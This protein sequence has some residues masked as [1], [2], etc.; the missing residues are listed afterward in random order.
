LRKLAGKMPP[1]LSATLRSSERS[2]GHSG[3]LTFVTWKWNSTPPLGTFDGLLSATETYPLPQATDWTALATGIGGVVGAE[4]GGVGIEGIEVG[5]CT[6]RDFAALTVQPV[7]A[8]AATDTTRIRFQVAIIVYKDG[9]L[10]S[11]ALAFGPEGGNPSV[12]RG[13]VHADQLENLRP[14]QR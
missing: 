5:G 10:A 14:I 8:R 7:S 9:R 6:P 13:M 11:P 3:A 4:V 12:R 1:L 2:N